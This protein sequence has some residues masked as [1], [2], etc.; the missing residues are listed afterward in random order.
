MRALAARDILELWEA[1]QQERPV[2]RA[3]MLVR[4]ADPELSI[5]D[6]LALTVAERDARLYR[7][8][9]A[10]FGPV[11]DA[12]ADCPRCR[13]G[14]VFEVDGAWFAADRPEKPVPSRSEYSLSAGDFA[15]RFRLPDSADL[16]AAVGSASLAPD[17]ARGKAALVARCVTEAR[18]GGQRVDLGELPEEIVTELAAR[19]AEAQPEAEVLLDLE[20]AACGHRWQAPLDIA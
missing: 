16:L 15:L 1:G 9:A 18:R 14:V 8:R 11:L 2:T 19:M 17:V 10:T 13:E 3:L 5:D 20:C 6:G 12:Y 4:A 7:V